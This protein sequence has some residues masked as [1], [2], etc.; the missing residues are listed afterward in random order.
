MNKSLKVTYLTDVLFLCAD[1]AADIVTHALITDVVTFEE[2][3]CDHLCDLLFGLF[4]EVILHD[5]ELNDAIVG[6]QTALERGCVALINLIGG[7]VE[8][9]DRLVVAQVL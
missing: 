2:V 9:S 7:D 5:I 1:D 4:C 6:Q 8:L 3:L